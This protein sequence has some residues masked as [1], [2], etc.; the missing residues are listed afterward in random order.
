MRLLLIDIKSKDYLYAV[1]ELNQNLLDVLSNARKQLSSTMFSYGIA[2][3]SD[4]NIRFLRSRSKDGIKYPVL[5]DRFDSYE[6]VDFGIIE[7]KEVFDDFIPYSLIKENS[8]AC[9][10]LR[11]E[12][13]GFLAMINNNKRSQL[14]Q[15]KLLTSQLD[16]INKNL[17][18]KLQL[19]MFRNGD[20]NTNN[21]HI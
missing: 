15:F 14:V 10:Y 4:C 11:F 19:D 21:T 12:A 5:I 3:A 6:T 17:V 20:N 9:G 16:A 8:D 2:G 18:D 1:M 13:G 7:A